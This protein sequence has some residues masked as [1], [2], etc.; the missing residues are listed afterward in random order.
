MI[1]KTNLK[2]LKKGNKDINQSSFIRF[3]NLAFCT[4]IIFCSTLPVQSAEN[5]VFEPLNSKKTPIPE[6]SKKDR[7]STINFGDTVV[8]DYSQAV[9]ENGN[10]KFPVSIITDDI[11]V[12]SLDYQFR[13]NTVDFTYDQVLNTNSLTSLLGNLNPA[14]HILRVFSFE[15][16]VLPNNTDLITLS[17]NTTSTEFCALN[18]FNVLVY[19]NGEPCSYKFIGCANEPANAGLNQNICACNVHD[20]NNVNA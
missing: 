20:V 15:D 10:L 18:P 13:F 12:F 16:Y 7:A 8:F 4:A 9:F 1:Y 14:D 2:Q 11:D 5:S 3:L 17:F 6:L 19:L